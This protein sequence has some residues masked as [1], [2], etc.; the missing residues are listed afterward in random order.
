LK[1]EEKHLKI[2][3]KPLI[4]KGRFFF[5]APDSLRWEYASPVQSILL[6]HEG[7]SRRYVIR[8]GVMVEDSA[9]NLQAMQVVISEITQ[10]LHGRFDA[11]PDF[12]ATLEPGPQVLLTPKEA[13]LA[14]MIE[15]IELNLS[16][17]P[18]L[19]KSVVIHEGKDTFTLLNFINPTLN[20]AINKDLFL[21]V[22]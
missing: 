9:A 16:D 10:W 8:D 22:E 4:S 5:S 21:S 17:Q 13:A 2:L 3:N 15:K 1:D 20:Q 14:K 6:M 11:N 19:M 12:H 7:K 18:G